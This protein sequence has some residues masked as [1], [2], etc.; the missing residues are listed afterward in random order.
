VES[1]SSHNNYGTAQFFPYGDFTVYRYQNY[2]EPKS[3]LAKLFKKKMIK[4]LKKSCL[5]FE[6]YMNLLKNKQ[7]HQLK[8]YLTI[9]EDVFRGKLVFNITNQ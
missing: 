9:M 4:N 2:I 5:A 3:V 6:S 8:K 7:P 1:D